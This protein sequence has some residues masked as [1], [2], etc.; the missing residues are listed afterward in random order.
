MNLPNKLTI[1]R[2]LLVPLLIFFMLTQSVP[3]NY[4]WALI[5][6]S[7]ASLTDF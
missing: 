3:H 1:L 4:L 6:F 2:V 7:A 5:V